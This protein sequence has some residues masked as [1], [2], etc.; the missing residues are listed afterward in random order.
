MTI[1]HAPVLGG[2]FQL[3]YEELRKK[4]GRMN[5]V[6]IVFPCKD[7]SRS[8]SRTGAK[9]ETGWMFIAQCKCIIQLDP[10]IMI[11]EMV[12]NVVNVNN[13]VELSR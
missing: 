5:V 7:F 11:I 8:G 4:Y 12:D 6:K 9:G 3:N 10:D 2:A 13:G 1:T